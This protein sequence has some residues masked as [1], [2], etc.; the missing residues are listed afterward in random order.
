MM[1]TVAQASRETI[2]KGSTSFAAAARLFDSQTRD[3]ASML[4]AW[5]RYCDDQIDGQEL[6]HGDAG[7]DVATQRERLVSLTEKT[8]AALA[9]QP[10]E[11]DAVFAAFQ[12]VALRHGIPAVHPLD[13]LEGF[14]MDVEGRRYRTIEELLVYCYHVAGVV[15][16]MMAMIMGI[17]DTP[18]LRH[19]ADLGLGLQLTN[20]ARDVI[21]DAARGRV[22]L[23]EDWLA[24]AGV[25]LDGVADPAHRQAV[26]AVTRRLLATAEPYYDSAR[27]GLR[28][29]PFRSAWAIAAARGVYREIGRAVDRSG[30]QAMAQRTVVSS[31]K[32]LQL[33]IS[34]GLVAARAASVDQWRNPPNVTLALSA[35]LPVGSITPHRLQR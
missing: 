7:L 34:S 2:R 4:Y 17:R 29:L 31:W 25:P 5:C 23:P 22:Y 28:R 12:R 19:A 35:D 10:V 9:G 15:G 16:V 18:T 21:E 27:W 20:I 14:R 33:V 32:K 26:F 8:R 13:L 6:G 11:D 3:D 1:D 24:E 30:P